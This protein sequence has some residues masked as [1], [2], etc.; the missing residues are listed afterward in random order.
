MQGQA[1]REA[2]QCNLALPLAGGST[3]FSLVR[4]LSRQRH[5]IIPVGLIPHDFAEAVFRVTSTPP[6]WAGFQ[7]GRPLVM[8][9]LNVTPDSFSDGGLHLDAAAAVAAGLR[10]MTEGADIID[11]GGESTRPGAGEV[12]AAVEQDRVL[13]VV[14]ALA[15]EGAK[16]SIDTRHAAT[17]LAGVRLGASIINDVSG[18]SFDPAF[19]PALEDCSAA[20]IAMHMRGDPRTMQQH[21]S[22]GD[23]TLEVIQE[24]HHTLRRLPVALGRVAVDPGIGFAKGVGHNEALL[25]RLPLLLNLGCRIVV[26]VSRKGF[27]GRIAREPDVRA[28]LPGSL[29][30]ALAAVLGG[31]SILRVHDVAAT[32]QALRVWRAIGDAA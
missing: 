13:P 28:R 2:V 8:G 12:P 20:L 25:A 22:Y 6:V 5:D 11:V 27:I 3:A 9:I 17:A 14:E 1:A 15:G 21:A 4:L 10:M 30:A 19:G 32:M 29:A 16:I 23:V 7:H 26:G 31:A 24:L 18:F